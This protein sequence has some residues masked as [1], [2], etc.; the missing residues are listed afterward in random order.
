M[1][2]ELPDAGYQ[3]PHDHMAISR[4]FIAQARKELEDDDR[5]QASEKLW[6]A[7]AHALKSIAA[8]R[9]WHHDDHLLI[10]QIAT[11]LSDEFERPH[12]DANVRF[13]ESFHVNFYSN[14]EQADNIERAINLV[15]QLIADLDLVR[16]ASPRPFQV[17]NNSQRN[18]LQFLLGRQVG[19]DE[20]SEDGFVNHERLERLRQR[21]ERQN[22][23]PSQGEEA[24]GASA[25]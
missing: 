22:L 9:G 19:A 6:G 3:T 13:A 16:S 10:K 12:F 15:E 8:Q 21:R 5:L 23:A 14:M 2:L 4:R 1:T 17:K 7:T 24:D 18:R 11:Q 20:S 25:E